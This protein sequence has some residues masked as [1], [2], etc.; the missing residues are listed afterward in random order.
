MTKINLKTS[1]NVFQP[2]QTTYYLLEAIKKKISKRKKVEIIDM[3]CGNGVLGISLLKIFK[4][5][6]NLVFT[7]V[8][9]NSL[10]DCENNIKLNYLKKK[11]YDLIISNVFS[12]IP[13]Q[14]FDIIINDISG[15]SETVAKLSPWFNNIS[16]KSGKNG[17][18][19]TIKFLKNY[20]KFLKKSGKVFFPIISLSNEK[21]IFDYLKTNNIKYKIILEKKWPLPQSMMKYIKLLK[22]LKSKKY[23]N[24]EE[25]FGLAVASTKIIYLV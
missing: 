1:I 10:K 23:I 21:I 9:S 6:K 24:Y 19:L 8:S 14:K 18:D 25:Q 3:G 22:Q 11:K 16:C 20:Q 15:I 13:A 5:I 17:T 12:K 7:D 2:T 4:N